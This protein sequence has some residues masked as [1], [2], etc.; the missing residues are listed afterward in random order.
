MLARIEGPT[1]IPEKKEIPEPNAR[2]YA[3]MKDDAKAGTFKVVTGQL[4]CAN[5]L[6]DSGKLI[7]LPQLCLLIV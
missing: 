7:L 1:D 5:V 3:Y 6:F 4:K 2:I